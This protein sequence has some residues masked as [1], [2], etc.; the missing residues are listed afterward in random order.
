MNY[1]QVF[2]DKGK[3]LFYKTKHSIKKLILTHK[4]VKFFML[5]LGG[6]QFSS[7]AKI[8]VAALCVDW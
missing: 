2:T 6:Y 5:N 7:C 3:R 1:L 4:Y 8:Y